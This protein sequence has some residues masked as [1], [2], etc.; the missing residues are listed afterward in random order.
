MGPRSPPTDGKFKPLERPVNVPV[1]VLAAVL[2]REAQ[3]RAIV[4]DFLDA[5]GCL[6]DKRSTK[7]DLQQRGTI[8]VPQPQHLVD[9]VDFDHQLLF[10]R[11]ARFVQPIP[12]AANR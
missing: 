11:P 4:T 2:L 7:A 8:T 6:R 5:V 3:V 10:S 1:D 9:K 12:C